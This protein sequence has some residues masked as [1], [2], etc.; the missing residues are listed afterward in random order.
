[1][2]NPSEPL[3][4]WK[5]VYDLI[6]VDDRVQRSLA[7]VVSQILHVTEVTENRIICGWWTFDK[8]TGA[9]IDDDLEWGPSYGHTGSFLIGLI[10]NGDQILEIN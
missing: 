10:E 7:G 5:D 9:E 6:K 8:Q 4:V 3:K 1:M 2:N